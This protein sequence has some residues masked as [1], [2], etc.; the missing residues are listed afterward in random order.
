M[1][2][3]T[4]WE[5]ES[6]SWQ[7]V[8]SSSS[9][10][11]QMM[12]ECII[13]TPEPWDVTHDLAQCNTDQHSATQASIAM[14]QQQLQ[15]V[16][17]QVAEVNSHVAHMQLQ[18]VAQNAALQQC[19]ETLARLL[20][21]GAPQYTH[22]VGPVDCNPWG[23][24][25]VAC[26]PPAVPA[27]MHDNA[28]P[29][30]WQQQPSPAPSEAS[31][32]S[33]PVAHK[34]RARPGPRE[35]LR[36]R[37]LELERK[38]RDAEEAIANDAANRAMEVGQPPEPEVSLKPRRRELRMELSTWPWRIA[39]VTVAMAAVAHRIAVEG[40][41]F[42]ILGRVEQFDFHKFHIDEYSEGVPASVMNATDVVEISTQGSH[43]I[44]ASDGEESIEKMRHFGHL[45][46]AV[47]DCRAAAEWFG[48]AVNASERLVA[49][50]T[51]SLTSVGVGLKV[52]Q[53][54]LRG[55]LGLALTCAR[56]YEDAIENIEAAMK[57]YEAPPHWQNAL[58]LAYFYRGMFPESVK[59]FKTALAKHGENPI[60]WNN[61]AAAAM[62]LSNMDI[63]TTDDALYNA[64]IKVELLKNPAQLQYYRQV[65][66][67][68]VHIYRAR[69]DGKATV[70]PLPARPHVETYNCVMREVESLA[71]KGEKP[72]V[73]RLGHNDNE[74]AVVD[75]DVS[76]PGNQDL[77]DLRQAVLAS[78]V[79]RILCPSEFS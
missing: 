32:N 24:T 78:A 14:L 20:T 21:A 37:Q 53:P 33:V 38:Q 31:G 61:L 40:S 36:Q 6:D 12:E 64:L 49:S 23:N 2:S 16:C 52:L 50:K 67:N 58:G 46:L 65:I 43:V 1:H 41:S 63:H 77:A 68:N 18:Q 66:A 45:R 26:G 25:P 39:F 62:S 72:F 54:K 76:R 28:P 70:G 74:P 55:D 75:V 19:Q 17:N 15:Q 71:Y 42:F 9:E 56:R 44:D 51:T 22:T 27:Y 8:S 30:H 48:K 59:V 29:E 3:C 4:T 47:S 73:K 7:Q 13:K 11:W 69:A 60:L 57:G 10:V 79:E 5:G 34:P 35:R